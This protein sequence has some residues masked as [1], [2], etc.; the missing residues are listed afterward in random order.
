[1]VSKPSA[2]GDVKEA[3][4]KDRSLK[5]AFLRKPPNNIVTLL[6]SVIPNRPPT[7]FFQYPPF[8]QIVRGEDR[9]N[10]VQVGQA[11]LPNHGQLTFRINRSTHTYNCVVNA[12]KIA[13]F[14]VTEK[15][16]DWNC[17]W[18][19]LI[20][21]GRLRQLN[22]FQKLNHFAG[23]WAIGHKG[24]L[25]RNVARQKARFGREFDVCP[26]T[27]ILPEDWKR[28]CQE[29]ELGNYKDMYI[30]KPTCGSCGR[31]I[32]V[33]GRMQKVAKRGAGYLIQQYI[34]RPHL[35]RGYKYDMRIYVVVTGF[36]PLKAYF[37]PEGLVRLATQPYT[38]AKGELKKR[39][40]HLTNF[41][42][43]KKAENY[44]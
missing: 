30:M 38:T 17:L 25:W 21:A 8:L 42:I 43:N 23:A 11:D 16:N 20:R 6:R 37:F 44:K 40:I 10:L 15:G 14:A 28:W 24:N 34:Q 41:S 18:T 2:F 19:G 4:G 9:G 27:Y 5:E 31:G 1:M 33:I 29:R 26:Q 36:E 22:A 35:L 3:T 7:V 39:F 12:F 13:G 32:K